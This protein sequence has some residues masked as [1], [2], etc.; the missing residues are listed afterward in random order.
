M[1]PVYVGIRCDHHAVVPQI[2]QRVFYIQGML[3]QVELLVLIYD[4]LG[5]T[6]TVQGFTP[7]TEYCLS[8]CIPRFGDRTAGRIALRNENGGG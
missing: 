7:Q 5:Q 6:I 1:H 3:Q 2:V 4:L 8:I